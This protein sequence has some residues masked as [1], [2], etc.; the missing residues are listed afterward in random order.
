MNDGLIEQIGSP[1]QLYNYP[2]NIFVAEFIGAPQMNIL[3]GIVKADS[4]RSVVSMVNGAQINC[5]GYP[6]SDGQSVQVGI[7]PQ[8]LQLDS[9]GTLQATVQLVEPM[10]DETH[11]SCTIEEEELRIVEASTVELSA[12]DSV[13]I[14]IEPG[15]VHIFDANTG[16]RMTPV[17]NSL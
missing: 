10:G 2:E 9:G 15:N 5:D 12:G 13:S 11:L 4:Q 6:V 3:P 1:I 17:E 16:R 7:R 14:S 8:H